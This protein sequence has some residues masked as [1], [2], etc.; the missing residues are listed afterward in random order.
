MNKKEN[1]D[2]L[3][4]DAKVLLSQCDGLDVDLEWMYSTNDWNVYNNVVER[5]ITEVM[6]DAPEKTFSC[7]LHAVSYNG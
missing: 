2:N 4:R 1:V 3:I 6:A 5:L 7:S